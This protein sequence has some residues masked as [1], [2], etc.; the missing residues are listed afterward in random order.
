[1]SYGQQ[2]KLS[3]FQVW[4]YKVK[5]RP[6]NPQS[7]KL[8]PKTINEYFMGY[9]VGSRGS[10]FYCKSHTTRVIE[11]NQAI[12][13]EDDIGTCQ[14]PRG[15]VF[16][17]HLVFITMPIAFAPIFSPVVHQHLIHIIGFIC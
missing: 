13:F 11:S 4:G 17:E 6:Y 9:C 3:H 8:D 12:Y 15:I 16:K 7:K 5:V 2:K 14:G 1:M 10:R